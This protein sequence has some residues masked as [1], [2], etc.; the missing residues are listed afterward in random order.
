MAKILIVDDETSILQVFQLA[1][2]SDHHE[3][4]TASSGEEAVK[5]IRDIFFDLVITDL[6]MPEFDGMALLKKIQEI[7]PETVVVMMTAYGSTKTAVE[8]MKLGAYDYLTKPIQ[9][10]DLQKTIQNAMSH[11]E[12]VRQNRAL[13]KVS[14]KN[15]KSLIGKSKQYYSIVRWIDQVAKVSASALILGESGTGKELVSREIH[16]RSDRSQYPFVPVNC[17]AIPEH[18]MESELFGYA[19]GA[20][21]GADQHRIGYFEAAHKGTIFLDEI[22]EIPLNLQSKLLR[23]LAE[24]KVVRLG[25]NR[26]I[27]VDVRVI[28][29]TNRP[30]DEQTKQEKFREDLF[31]RLNVLQ[32]SL[33]PLRD[34]AEDVPMLADHF[35]KKFS[36]EYR[37]DITGFDEKAIQALQ[38][39][40]F[41][42]NIRELVN[43]VEQ[44]VVLQEE[45]VVLL[46]MLPEKVKSVKSKKTGL[47]SPNMNLEKQV[48]GLERKLISEALEKAKGVKTKAAKL[49][50]ISFRS[51]R[52]RLEKL[53]LDDE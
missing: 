39:Y 52:Y 45:P 19:K 4:D 47:A 3:T 40:S 12:L 23:V 34:R 20:F 32:T 51:L 38:N 14:L 48:E 21:T 37:K 22:G 46:E 9:L 7:S 31:Y 15:Q 27:P 10:D 18:L 29:A 25:S 36:D 24:K 1:L 17:A 49:L 44:I 6:S 5:K 35:L 16:L 53:G 11:A 43:I 41:P 13:R 30:L 26:E 33:P 2:Q 28:S 50:N 8:A 42:G